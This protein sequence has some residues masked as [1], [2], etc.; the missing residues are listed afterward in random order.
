M[1][2]INRTLWIGNLE[3]WME[4]KHLLNFLKELNIYPVNIILKPKNNKRRSGFLIFDSYKTANYVLRNFNG[5]KHR[6]TYIKLN[7]IRNGKNIIPNLNKYTVSYLK[8]L[9]FFNSYLLE[10]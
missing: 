5:Y 7:W 10:I 8:F 1:S 2:I 4:Y 3:P 6:N 9:F